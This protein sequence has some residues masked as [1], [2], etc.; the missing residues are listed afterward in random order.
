MISCE[1]PRNVNNLIWNYVQPNKFHQIRFTCASGFHKKDGSLLV[2]SYPSDI[3]ADIVSYFL[4]QKSL[5]ILRIAIL[6]AEHGDLLLNALPEISKFL[7]SEA[8]LLF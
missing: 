2:F 7:L 1:R 5:S 6:Q 4:L 3:A 8:F